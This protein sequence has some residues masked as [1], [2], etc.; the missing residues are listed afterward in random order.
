MIFAGTQLAAQ[1]AVWRTS[2]R[3]LASTGRTSAGLLG[4]TSAVAY[5]HDEGY[6]HRDVSAGN[7]LIYAHGWAVSDWGFVYAPP[8]GGLRMTQ[9]L[10]RFGTPEFMAPEMVLDPRSVGRAA[11]IFSIGRLAAWVTGLGRGMV[12]EDDDSLVRWWRTLIDGTTAYEPDARWT[13]RD[14]ETH[15]RSSVP[16]GPS[17]AVEQITQTSAV[18]RADV[19]PLCLS[20]AGRD[21]AE[22]CLACHA[23]AVY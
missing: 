9:P 1:S 4:V 6:I 21:Q 17:I 3:W 23:L 7:T 18:A 10:E 19:C 14:L 22:R 12:D 11:D 8:K 15:L 13:M 2:G 16:V 5:A 20:G